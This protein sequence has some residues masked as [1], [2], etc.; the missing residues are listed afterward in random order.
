MEAKNCFKCGKLKPL[1]EFYKHPQMLD[2][3][4]NKCKECTKQDVHE[5]RWSNIEK[6]RKYDRD[7]AKLPHRIALAIKITKKWRAKDR[8][9]ARCHGLVARALRS[10][11]LVPQNC[12]CC[13]S[14]QT[15]AHHDNY[16]K[17]L[18]VRWLCQPCHKQWHKYNEAF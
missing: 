8:R 11:D 1:N 7:R 9:R 2:G 18:D 16:N 5:H 17:P 13:G 4:L 12:E 10:G 6:I 15:V 14:E 3:H